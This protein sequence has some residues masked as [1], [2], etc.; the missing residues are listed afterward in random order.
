MYVVSNTTET[1]E[2]EVVGPEE[3]LVEVIARFQGNQFR[4]L[5]ASLRDPEMLHSD[6]AALVGVTAATA[7]NWRYTIEGFKAAHD[8]VRA[9]RSSLRHEYAKLAFEGAI[10]ALADAMIERGKGTGRDAQRAG[11][12]IL[13]EVGVLHKETVVVVADPTQDML[14]ELRNLTSLAMGN[15]VE[16]QVVDA[17]QSA[18]AALSRVLGPGVVVQVDEAPPEA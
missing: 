6:V 12:R 17:E 7:Y 2:I 4:F 15:V 10:P 8:A 9:H 16:G 13:E 5:L 11:E 14:R 18:E 3:P 1:T